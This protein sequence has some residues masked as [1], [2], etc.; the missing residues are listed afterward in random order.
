MQNN[1]K[2]VYN[3]NKQAD[4]LEAGYNDKLE[5]AFLIEEALEEFDVSAII[6]ALKPDYQEMFEAS[7]DNNPNKPKDV[8]RFLVSLAYLNAQPLTK[9]QKLDKQIDAF[10]YAAGGIFKLGLSPQQAQEAISAVMHA[11]MKKV[12]AGKDE[13]GKQLKPDNWLEIEEQM[14]KKLDKLI[15]SV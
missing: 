4:L 13:Q 11:N 6:N 15:L 14:N 8:A 7:K 3:F 5:S 10:V 9:R 12:G 1:L 2:E